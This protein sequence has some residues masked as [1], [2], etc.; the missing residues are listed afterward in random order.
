MNTGEAAA[1][2]AVALALAEATAAATGGVRIASGDLSRAMGGGDLPKPGDTLASPSLAR[3]ASWV[4]CRPGT[5]G[6]AC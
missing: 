6:K 3:V 4:D 1:A 5:K 2:A